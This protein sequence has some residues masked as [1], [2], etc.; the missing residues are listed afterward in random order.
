[1]RRSEN[2]GFNHRICQLCKNE[3][4]ED[5]RH[6][7]ISCSVLIVKDT[8]FILVSQSVED[9]NLLSDKDRF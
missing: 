2:V 8:N 6:F 3:T 4:M 1:M 7:L 9:F 5:E